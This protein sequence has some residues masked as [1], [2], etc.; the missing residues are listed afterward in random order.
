M[1]IVSSRVSSIVGMNML[2]MIISSK[3]SMIAHNRDRLTCG[4]FMTH[5]DRLFSPDY[6]PSNQ[7][8]LLSRVRTSGIKEMMF[9]NGEINHHL[10][11]IG[12]TRSERVKWTHTFDGIHHLIFMTPLSGYDECLVE[13]NTAVCAPFA[14]NLSCDSA[15][16]H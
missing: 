6:V 10:F 12:G 9:V 13:D 2:C 8:V 16:V 11:N 3:E 7:D 15:V 14:R 5:I 1:L 4:S